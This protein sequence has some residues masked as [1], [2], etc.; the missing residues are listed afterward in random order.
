MPQ[1]WLSAV[2]GAGGVAF[3]GALFEG[4]RR[5]MAGARARERE[6]V[7]NLEE[8]RE[9]ADKRARRALDDADYQRL[10]VAFWQRRSGTLEYL[11]ASNGVKVPELPA[12]PKRPSSQ[13]TKATK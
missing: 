4:V 11:L 9:D 1:D 3:L 7:A 13:V 12:L 10:L 5:L 6:A 2:L 8:W